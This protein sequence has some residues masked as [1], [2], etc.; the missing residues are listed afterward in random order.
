MIEDLKGEEVVVE[1]EEVVVEEE[2][3]VEEENQTV[4]LSE[5]KRRLARAQKNHEEEIR[6]LKLEKQV[7]VKKAK[8][9]QAEKKVFE[10]E[11]REKSL[12]A[13]ERELNERELKNKVDTKLADSNLPK[14]FSDLLIGLEDEELIDLKIAELKNSMD[15][16]INEN[17]KRKIGQPEPKVET[18]NLKGKKK[19]NR[20]DIFKK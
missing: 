7:E 11:E 13:K 17:V 5:L 3:V 1:E 9:T 6:K 12:L 15:E 14:V 18:Y 19:M 16:A 8:M 2:E 10:I 20:S 4:P